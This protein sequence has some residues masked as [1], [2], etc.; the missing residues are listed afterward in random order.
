MTSLL[1][2]AAFLPEQG[3]ADNELTNTQ[4][5]G[6]KGRI[7]TV[8]PRMWIGMALAGLCLFAQVGDG[9]SIVLLVSIIGS[10]YA[11]F[12]VHRIHKVFA[13]Y[14]LNRYPISPRKAVL[15]HFIPVFE[16]YW[17]FRWSHQIFNFIDGNEVSAGKI[18]TKWWLGTLLT[19]VSILGWFTPFK[20]LRLFVLFGIGTY[21]TR[22]LKAALPAPR[23]LGFKRWQQWSLSMCAGIGAAFS[24]VLVEAIRHFSAEQ[25]VEKLH[26]LGSI[27]LVSIGMLIFLEPL[28]EQLRTRLGVAEHHPGLPPKRTVRIAVFAILV[29]TS[30]FHGLLHHE[31]E[32]GM[33][34]D[35][36]GTSTVV[37]AALLVSGGITFFWVGAA[38]CFPS[39]AARSG[40]MS[41][42]VLGF[43][44][45]FAVLAI[46]SSSVAGD[47]PAAASNLE[48]ALA[49]NFPLAPSRIMKL[50]DDSI[51][52]KVGIISLP[53]PIFGLVGG[54]VI[55][56]RWGKVKHHT[57]AATIIA[58][59]LLYELLLLLIRIQSL[60]VEL[61]SH[62]SVAVG[63]GL[64]LI[65]CSSSGAL[66]PQE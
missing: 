36:A 22:R 27:F 13:E 23:P 48:E 31:I 52:T 2:P 41:G 12:C 14:T 28:F 9:D 39:H 62:L 8:L 54:F 24:F 55:D 40:L 19:T 26:E 49:H 17:L 3:V 58:T 30:L 46:S 56:R 21:I 38:H 16:Y 37:L 53:W 66:T 29:F 43:L 5:N 63:W 47:T 50:G 6:K 42:T 25:Q 1:Q 44:V 57:L 45:A 7:Y 33:E 64:A 51:M 35:W 4:S 32:T 65:V 15:F 18:K 60:N 59:A 10:C 11:L 34:K 20:A 61:L